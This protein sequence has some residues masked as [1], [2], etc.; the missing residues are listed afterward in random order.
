MV[1]IILGLLVLVGCKSVPPEVKTAIEGDVASWRL[2]KKDLVQTMPAGEE[3]DRWMLR[4]ASFI[5]R[6]RSL[7]AWAKD[8]EFDTVAAVKEERGRTEE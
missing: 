1:F 5:T 6:A 2:V 8:E 4:L 3:R 7:E